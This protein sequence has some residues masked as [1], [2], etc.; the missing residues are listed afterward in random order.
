MQLLQN[1]IRV[2]VEPI[3]GLLFALALAAFIWGAFEFMRGS[4]NEQNVENAKNKMLWGIVGLFIMAA[5]NGLV[6]LICRTIE[7]T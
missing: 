4:G 2:I 6:N 5:A 1:I 3:V 7:C